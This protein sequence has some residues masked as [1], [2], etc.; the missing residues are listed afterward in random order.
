MQ[1]SG[2]QD[3]FTHHPVL[4]RFVV[5]AT[6]RPLP[7]CLHRPPLSELAGYVPLQIQVREKRAGSGPGDPV[8]LLGPL[9][10]LLS[11]PSPHQP[12]VGLPLLPLPLS[13]GQLERMLSAELLRH[14]MLSP[15]GPVPEWVR[16]T[17]NHALDPATRLPLF[18]TESKLSQQQF[19]DW[20]G[21]SRAQLAHQARLLSA[22]QVADTWRAPPSEPATFQEWARER[23]D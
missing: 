12:P 9:L 16:Q 18:G 20:F 23:T 1:F 11:W 8:T 7:G 21:L 2:K 4:A 10:P 19:A 17:L 15:L 22:E 5:A 13:E 14:A 3:V 6:R